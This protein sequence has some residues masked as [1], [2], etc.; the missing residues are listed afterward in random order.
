M[1]HNVQLIPR[2]SCL[3]ATASGERTSDSVSA[4]AKEI[5]DQCMQNGI[6]DVYLDLRQLKGRL[7]IS[8]S[9]AVITRVFPELGLLGKLQR[10]A[11]LESSG[12][13]ERSRFFERAA[14]ARGYNIR[15]F[16][17]EEVAISWV[18]GGAQSA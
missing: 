10:V 17:D 2:G 12:R 6:A 15:M 1:S 13:Y 11:V 3:F 16:E 18:T 8:D 9:I 5:V 7:D 4:I 14:H